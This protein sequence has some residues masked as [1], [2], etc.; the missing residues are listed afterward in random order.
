MTRASSESPNALPY[1]MDS[2]KRTSTSPLPTMKR[3]NRQLLIDELLSSLVKNPG[4][5]AVSLQFLLFR[6]ARQKPLH[7]TRTLIGII[8]N[9]NKS[10][11]LQ[12]LE[13][14][15]NHPPVPSPCTPMV[16]GLHDHIVGAHRQ[17][18]QP[19]VRPWTPPPPRAPTR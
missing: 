6:R 5:R 16:P 9:C 8:I 2:A 10:I 17:S 19:S 11:H 18:A 3:C 12:R 7:Q 14:C 15:S 13:V 1:T 4:N